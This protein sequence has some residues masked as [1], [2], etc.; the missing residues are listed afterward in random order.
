[1]QL[2]RLQSGDGSEGLSSSFSQNLV[3]M[4][5]RR[6]A[7]QISLASEVAETSLGQLLSGVESLRTVAQELN[8]LIDDA[9]ETQNGACGGK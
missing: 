5:V 8:A 3:L 6:A 7:A 2:L 4:R 1:M 9:E